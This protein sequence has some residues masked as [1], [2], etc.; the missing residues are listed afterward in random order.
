MMKRNSV[1]R[2]CVIWCIGLMAMLAAQARAQVTLVRPVDIYGGLKNGTIHVT[3]APAYTGDTLKAF[4]GN[5]L[6]AMEINNSDTLVL[7]V[8]SDSLIRIERSIVFFWTSGNWTLEAADS[9][10]DLEAKTG[11]YAKLL[12]SRPFSAFAWDS[13][14]FPQHTA[15]VVRLRAKNPTGSQ[16]ILGEW[17]LKGSVTFTKLVILPYPVYVLPAT[18]LQLDL[19]MIDDHNNVYPYFLD[20]PLA[21]GTSDHSVAVVD[22]YGKLTGL[23]IGSTTVSVAAVG[24]PISGFATAN[25]VS[26]FRPQKIDPMHVKVALVVED[27][28]IAAENYKRIHE[29]FNW[30]DPFVLTRRLV[31][32]FKEASDSVVNFEIVDTVDDNKLF[33]YMNDTLL[34]ATRYYNLLKEPGWITLRSSTERFNYVEMVNYYGFDQMR[35]NGAIDEIWVF[36]APFLGM[37]ESQLMGPNAFWWNSPPIKT[38]TA[39]T[40]LLSVM[41]LNYERGVDQ[42]FHSFGHRFESAMSQAY[43]EAQGLNWNSTRTNPTPW[44][45]FTRLDKD[46]PG[47]AHVGNVHYPP[48]GMT[49]YDYGNARLVTS[50]AQNWYRYPY[51]LDQTAQVNLSTW[52]YHS[53]QYPNGDRLAEGQDHLGFL[54]WWYNHMPRYVG[55]KDGVLNNWWNYAVD[56]EGAVALAKATPLVGVKDQRTE[57]VPKSFK[58]GQN[59]PNPFNPTTAISYQLPT[60]SYVTLKIYDMLGREVATLVNEQKK[61]GTYTVNWNATRMASGVYFYRLEASQTDGTHPASFT[62]TRKLVL[63][64]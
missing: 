49:D 12:D 15:H 27:P 9:L 43:Y 23:S 64:K 46:M 31:E 40:K 63:V 42:A 55:V 51:L 25:V 5:Q 24:K 44:D 22:E 29:I 61:P 50:Y 2:T 28:R 35:N 36:A 26:D 33:T 16:V 6:N 45:R 56:Y 58:L 37:Y 3:I 14:S 21:W 57:A 11:S 17:T 39:L 53:E 30:R 52:I 59:F 19:R 54:R 41:G 8:Q 4:D 48:N 20:A 13:V 1:K 32:L 34:T 62:E 60:N 7:T 38:G 18:S 47:E 10:S